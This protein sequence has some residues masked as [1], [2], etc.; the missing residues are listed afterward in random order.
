MPRHWASL[1]EAELLATRALAHGH[2]YSCT[3]QTK[4]YAMMLVHVSHPEG[5]NRAIS[6]TIF[7]IALINSIV[8]I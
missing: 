5:V 4:E 3:S 1:L 6:M 8:T 7:L 2:T